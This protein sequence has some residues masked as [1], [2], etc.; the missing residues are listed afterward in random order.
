MPL[1]QTPSHIAADNDSLE[2]NKTQIYFCQEYL[3]LAPV[4]RG[5]CGHASLLGPGEQLLEVHLGR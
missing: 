5:A 2:S 1:K 3:A 4:Q